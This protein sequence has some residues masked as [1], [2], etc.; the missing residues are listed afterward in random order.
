MAGC[1]IESLTFILYNIYQHYLHVPHVRSLKDFSVFLY[2][3]K[4]LNLFTY[5]KPTIKYDK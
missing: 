1:G 3:S 4:K 5:M 2:M